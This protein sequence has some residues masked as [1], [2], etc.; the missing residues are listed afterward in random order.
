MRPLA[1]VI[2]FDGTVTDRD[3]GD[4]IV[5][6]F[7]LPGWDALEKEFH[8]GEATIRQLWAQEI[9]HLPG[10]RA[11]EMADFALE[12]ASV[13]PGLRELVDYAIAQ[14]LPIEVAS[15]GI[16]FYLRRIL[17][18]NG[19]SDLPYVCLHAEFAADGTTRLVFPGGIVT[20]A[21][22]GLCKCARVWRMQRMARQVMFVGDGAS[23]ACVARE[24]DILAARASLARMAE[25][26]GRAYVPFEDFRDVLAAVKRATG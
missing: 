12:V 23:D 20:C 17:E 9:S 13:R 4:A 3:I 10:D 21:R 6:R 16:E 11:A 15:N 18:E 5:T 7:G 25:L 22:N 19:L 2:D 8:A 1:I 24:P 26:D 14:G